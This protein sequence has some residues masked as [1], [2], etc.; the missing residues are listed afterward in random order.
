MKY[1]ATDPDYNI[2]V[3]IDKQYYKHNHVYDNRVMVLLLNDA[4]VSKTN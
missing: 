2:H 4:K 3:H 1:D